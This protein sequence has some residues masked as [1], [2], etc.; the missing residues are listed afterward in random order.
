MRSLPYKSI[1]V[2][3]VALAGAALLWLNVRH[4]GTVPAAPSAAVQPLVLESAGP[5]N[6]AVDSLIEHAAAGR[7]HQ[8]E[9]DAETMPQDL[10]FHD[11]R[12]LM[13]FSFGP[14]PEKLPPG[15]WNVVVNNI[16]NALRLQKTP[17]P[18]FAQEMMNFFRNPATTPVLKDYAIQHLGGWVESDLPA[19]EG[20]ADPAMRREILSFLLD[21]AGM[22]KEAFAGTA[23]YSLNGAIQPSG[24]DENTDIG[25]LNASFVGSLKDA[26]L[27]LVRDSAASPLARISA[28][29]IV[30]KHKDL[31]A[32][33]SARQVALD[34]SAPPMLRASAIACLGK[35]GAPSDLDLLS[36]VAAG[37]TDTRLL[38]A[39]KPAMECL[40]QSPPPAGT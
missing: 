39:L 34:D 19:G 17:P 5:L 8:A 23:L 28:F 30:R 25:K 38:S 31:R 11:F 32:L 6:P 20:E 35:L 21:V 4:G 10:V 3:L 15:K 37:C 29:Q 12:R 7:G 14:C 16:W 22:K 2:V 24:S 13:W 9:V 18:E 36:K 1:A 33:P 27:A 40:S 26:A